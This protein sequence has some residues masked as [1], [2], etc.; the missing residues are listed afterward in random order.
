MDREVDMKMPMEKGVLVCEKSA[1]GSKLCLQPAKDYKRRYGEA[2][3]WPDPKMP[4][5]LCDKHAR[6]RIPLDQPY[7]FKSL[8][9]A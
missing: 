1:R 9:A 2:K 5:A 3:G 7:K 6:N 4:I 8:D